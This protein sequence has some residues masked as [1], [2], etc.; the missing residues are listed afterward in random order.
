MEADIISPEAQ[1]KTIKLYNA[2]MKKAIRNKKATN[3]QIQIYK[4]RQ[5]SEKQKHI[6]RSSLLNK[7]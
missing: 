3:E 5:E 7:F 6:R 4:K 2:N 1:H